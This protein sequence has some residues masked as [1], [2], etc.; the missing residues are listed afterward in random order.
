MARSEVV[1]IGPA[2]DGRMTSVQMWSRH[3]QL[4]ASES[5]GRL[6]GLCALLPLSF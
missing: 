5:L 1:G 4:L 3:T 2:A 6:R